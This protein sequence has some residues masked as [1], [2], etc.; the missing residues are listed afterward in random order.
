MARPGGGVMTVLGG[1]AG[2]GAGIVT[3]AAAWLLSR[4]LHHIPAA[5]PWLARIATVLMFA[6]GS[7]V[8]VTS[9][10][11][12]IVTA[13]ATIAGLLGGL[14]SGV[15]FAVLTVTALCLMTGVVTDL[16]WSPGS[17][18]ITAAVLPLVLGLTAGGVLHQIYAYAAVPAGQYAAAI[19][20]WIGG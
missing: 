13:V 12:W 5:S 1:L 8:A 6:G 14:H 10:G 16:I 20:S 15:A 9:L 7:A 3:L 2:S 19:A 18:M 11:G 4:H 17:G